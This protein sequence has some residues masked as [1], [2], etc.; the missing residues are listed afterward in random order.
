VK[1]TVNATK[2][3]DAIE[4]FRHKHNGPAG[5]PKG[6]KLSHAKRVSVTINVRNGDGNYL[7][8]WSGHWFDAGLGA[9]GELDAA[10]V[11]SFLDALKHKSPILKS[12]QAYPHRD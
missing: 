10:A 5:P 8:R 4:D 3:Q 11:R 2:I 1:P 7:K 12:E 9:D 6:K